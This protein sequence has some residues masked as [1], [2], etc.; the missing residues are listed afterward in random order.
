MVDSIRYWHKN[1]MGQRSGSNCSVRILQLPSLREAFIDEKRIKQPMKE[2]HHSNPNRMALH[3]SKQGER[4]AEVGALTSV[5]EKTATESQPNLL[6]C[7]KKKT[8]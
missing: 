2:N 3:V 4:S 8:C 7:K 1:L 5:F 6:K